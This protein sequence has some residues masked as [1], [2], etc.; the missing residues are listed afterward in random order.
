[1]RSGPFEGPAIVKPPALLGDTY[2]VLLG[3]LRQKWFLTLSLSPVVGEGRVRGKSEEQPHG[4]KII[5]VKEFV[6]RVG[7]GK[8]SF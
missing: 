3:Y 4:V 7:K 8:K 6:Q 2:Y 1:L 5:D